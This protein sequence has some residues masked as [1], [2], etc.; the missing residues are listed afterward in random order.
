MEVVKGYWL[1]RCPHIFLTDA[2]E[3]LP[4]VLHSFDE[5]ATQV[6]SVCSF[7]IMHPNSLGSPVNALRSIAEL[8]G[9]RARNA[10]VGGSN[11]RQK[12]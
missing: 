9:N 8:G 10:E 7:Y 5:V 6:V 3:M 4:L 11:R 2:Q 1:L 12:L